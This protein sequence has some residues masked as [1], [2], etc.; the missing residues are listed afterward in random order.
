MFTGYFKISSNEAVKFK[1][2]SVSTFLTV[3]YEIVGADEGF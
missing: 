2:V 3:S 1:K